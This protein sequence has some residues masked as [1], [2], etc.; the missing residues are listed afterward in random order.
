MFLN[1]SLAIYFKRF[2]LT[3]AGVRTLNGTLNVKVYDVYLDM[4]IFAML[5]L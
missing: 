4:Y 2:I 3:T 5:I 1:P